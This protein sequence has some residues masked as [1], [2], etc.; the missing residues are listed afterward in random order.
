MPDRILSSLALFGV[1]LGAG[2][3]CSVPPPATYRTQPGAADH[4]CILGDTRLPHVLKFWTSSNRQ[5]RRLLVRAVA[6]E[7]PAFVLMSGDFVQSGG[8]AR[9]WA[10]F[11][12]VFA[13]LRK[14]SV[15]VLP[16]LGNHDLNGGVRRGLNNYFARFPE[17]RRRR[18]YRRDYRSITLLMLDS[19]RDRLT[20]AQ[21]RR[22]RSWF[23]AQLAAA[24][25]DPRIRA[26]IVTL[27]HAPLTN[28]SK[29][30]DD[31]HVNRDLVPAFLRARKTVALV[32]AHVHTYERFVRRGKTFL[33][34][35]GGGAPPRSL[36]LGRRRRH[37]D[38]RF[39]GPAVR[40]FHYVSVRLTP[41][42]LVATTR[43]LRLGARRLHVM[44]RFTWP[45]PAAVPSPAGKG[46]R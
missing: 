7:R 29:H 13:P 16:A 46:S 36:Y 25:R 32:A 11:D 3:G 34:S 17:L 10:W 44:E 14:A 23:E 6:A 33:N 26:V 45:W 18:W 1:L 15:A 37:R 9:Q 2:V 40:P 21:W 39:S 5:E 31:P 30:A 43:G 24:D 42:G 38:D 19:N 22:Q 28:S 41:A 4:F 8:S 12:R 20:R 35:G 27:H